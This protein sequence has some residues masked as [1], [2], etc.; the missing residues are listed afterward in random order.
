MAKDGN[1][2]AP[3]VTGYEP[4][5]DHGKPSAPAILTEAEIDE[6]FLGTSAIGKLELQP[7]S[8]DRIIAAQA[9]LMQYGHVDEAGV[10]VY[11]RTKVYPGMVRDIA[12]HI[13]LRS[14]RNV[15]DEQ[16]P[17]R[18]LVTASAIIDRAQRDPIWAAKE[19][20]NLAADLGIIDT[21]DDPFWEAR[22]IFLTAM[23]AIRVART[24]AK[25]KRTAAQ[26]PA[27][28]G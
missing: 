22:E 9:M 24:E 10:E 3:A 1:A 14:V 16:D 13:W 21:D 15:M 4:D 7:Y 26:E 2:K 6:S 25:K 27:Q 20:S 19:A 17:S 5:E 12:N 28:Q 18:V 11:A 23:K 8:P